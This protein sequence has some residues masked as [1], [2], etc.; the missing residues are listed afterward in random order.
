MSL[1]RLD[2]RAAIERFSTWDAAV[3][4]PEMDVRVQPLTCHK[5]DAGPCPRLARNCTHAAHSSMYNHNLHFS[6]LDLS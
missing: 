3:E 1:H 6:T 4:N 5:R 2:G